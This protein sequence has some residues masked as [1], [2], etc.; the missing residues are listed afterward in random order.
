M[1]KKWDFTQKSQGS[2]ESPQ[3]KRIIA[4]P[5][6]PLGKPVRAKH[7]T[8]GEKEILQKLD[9]DP[10]EPIPENLAQLAEQIKKQDE[11]QIIK[12]FEERKQNRTFHWEPPVEIDEAPPQM[13][14]AVIE[15]MKAY[16]QLYGSKAEDTR[17]DDT[18]KALKEAEEQLKV[19]YVDLP[20][21]SE[22]ETSGSLIPHVNEAT[23]NAYLDAICMGDTF[24][25]TFKLF[26]DRVHVTFRTLRVSEMQPILLAAQL[27]ASK[28]S[29][30]AQ[31]PKAM[32]SVA[33]WVWRY[34]F[35]LQLVSIR[36]GPEF[37]I[38]A[39]FPDS[40]EGW[41]K[42]FGISD[43]A[44]LLEKIRSTVTEEV[45]R[46]EILFHALNSCFAEFQTL[47]NYLADNRYNEKFFRRSS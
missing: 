21:K 31:D 5:P 16:K 13:Q 45:V 23:I 24:R 19:E 44:Q 11:E 36:C 47:C 34:R 12:E 2:A 30:P 18:E 10:N 26:G 15:G 1:A 29:I 6:L 7:F 4:G 9:L 25:H 33:E 46:G 28:Q 37:G 41:Q 35:A 17:V 40:L 39:D 38:Q 32:L 22:V 8:E 14:Q 42:W 3:P 43:Q 27:A 20:D